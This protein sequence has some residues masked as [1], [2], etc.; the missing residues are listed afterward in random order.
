MHAA[1]NYSST[2][3]IANVITNTAMPM[4]VFDKSSTKRR[5][6]HANREPVFSECTPNIE[7]VVAFIHINDNDKTKLVLQSIGKS[8]KRKQNYTW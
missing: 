5:K 3:T 8:K 6:P 7:M 1:V 4:L 2:C